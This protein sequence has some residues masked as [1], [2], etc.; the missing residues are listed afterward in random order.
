MANPTDNDFVA[1]LG[2]KIQDLTAER[3]QLKPVIEHYERLAAQIDLLNRSRNAFLVGNGHVDVSVTPDTGRL[4]LR[5]ELGQTLLDILKEEGK[6]IHAE[7]LTRRLAARGIRAT[8]NAIAGALGR[9]YQLNEVERP[10]PRTYKV[11][12][13]GKL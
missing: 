10:A 12:L 6:P 8:Q 7:E 2:R 13:E 9:A 3:D 4:S 11:K 5:G 1:V